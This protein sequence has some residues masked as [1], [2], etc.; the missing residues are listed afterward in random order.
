[1][2]K[3]SWDSISVCIYICIPQ[4]KLILFL[5]KYVQ[6]YIHN[7]YIYTYKHSYIHTGTYLP[8]IIQESVCNL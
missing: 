6:N 7:I 4:N 1:M 5:K 2:K 3:V 8:M